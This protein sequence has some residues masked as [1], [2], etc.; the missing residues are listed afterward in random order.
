MSF[1]SDLT[2]HFWNH[3]F[4]DVDKKNQHIPEDEAKSFSNNIHRI[5]S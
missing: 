4:Q 1:I 5:T 2:M 3:C